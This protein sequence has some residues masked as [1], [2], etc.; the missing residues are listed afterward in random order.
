MSALGAKKSVAERIERI[1]RPVI[2]TVSYTA[3]LIAPDP[4]EHEPHPSSE[5]CMHA[6]RVMRRAREI[7]LRTH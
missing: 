3:L 1:L 6:V 5:S 4:R 7:D 2:M